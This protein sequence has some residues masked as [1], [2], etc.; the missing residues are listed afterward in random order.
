[1]KAEEEPF[2]TAGGCD[3]VYESTGQMVSLGS[4]KSQH[5]AKRSLVIPLINNF[6]NSPHVREKSYLF[7][8]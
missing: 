6:A 2:Q 7:Q 1:M 5:L 3:L 4:L 8:K